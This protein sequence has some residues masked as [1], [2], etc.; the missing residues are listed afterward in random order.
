MTILICN[1]GDNLFTDEI[2]NIFYII[3][4]QDGRLIKEI[5]IPYDKKKTSLIINKEQTKS[6]RPRNE[7][8]VPFHDSWILM[9]HSS[10][11]IYRVFTDKRVVPFIARTPSI[12]SMGTEI[13]LYPS[14]LTDRYY[15]MQTVKKVYDFSSRV[16]L[17]RTDLMYD[18]KENIIYE[19][20]LYNA[21]YVHKEFVSLG[22][23]GIAFINKEIAFVKTLEA[24]DL[25][26]AYK[27]GNLKGKLKEIAASLDEES[28]P[29]LMIAKYKQKK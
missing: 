7:E 6:A 19:Y 20:S 8:F 17:P 18:M 24:P 13:F 3:S 26:D 23:G 21:D 12:Q 27:N 16:G 29:V 1:D 25:V 15:F 28:N 22:Y 4:K 5:H 9:D 2:K 10:D 11:T 14:V